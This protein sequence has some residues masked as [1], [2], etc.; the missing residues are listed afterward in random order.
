MSKQPD[1]ICMDF[2]LPLL[3]AVVTGRAERLPVVPIPE[4]IHVATMGNDV[5][6]RGGFRTATGPCAA[7]IDLEECS[8]CRT[9]CTTISTA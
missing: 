5:V 6:N 3:L 9:P 4:Q 1:S 7:I 8:A 2:L